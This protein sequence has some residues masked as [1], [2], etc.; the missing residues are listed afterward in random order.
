[1]LGDTCTTC[2]QTISTC[3]CAEGPCIP[4]NDDGECGD[5]MNAACVFWKGSDI[6]GTPIKKN[7]RM[8][9]IILYFVSEIQT[10]KQKVYDLEN[11]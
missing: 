4:A 7:T 1:M 3:T 9:E 10:L 5:W 11:P 8:S 2:H 6:A